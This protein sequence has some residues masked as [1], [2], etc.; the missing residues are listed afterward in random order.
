MANKKGREGMLLVSVD[1]ATTPT[2]FVDISTQDNP[3]ILA[4]NWYEHDN[5]TDVEENPSEEKADAS[6]RRTMRFGYTA[7]SNIA[8]SAT[9]TFTMLNDPSDPMTKLLLEAEAAGTTVPMWD[10]DGD[11][12]AVTD[13]NDPVRGVAG[14]FSLLV[15]KS[16]PVKGLQTYQVTATVA[17]L[18]F[19][20]IADSA[21]DATAVGAIGRST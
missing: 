17:T 1:N 11:P 19:L 16:K 10:A 14:N 21:A 9:I 13:S 20:T 18:P 6:T 8:K 5:V 3:S 4:L 2:A 7:E 12:S 15:R